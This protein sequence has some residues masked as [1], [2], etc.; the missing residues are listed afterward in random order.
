MRIVSLVLVVLS[1]SVV[2]APEDGGGKPPQRERKTGT[3]TAERP[4]PQERQRAA[5]ENWVRE[6]RLLEVKG[7][8]EEVPVTVAEAHAELERMLSPEALALID[9]K[10]SEHD[11]PHSELTRDIVNGW[12]LAGGSA[13]AQHMEGFGFTDAYEMAV[14]IVDTFWCKRHGEEFRLEERAARYRELREA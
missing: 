1:L 2:A 6:V 9:A 14:T 5:L 11:V 7:K 8:I 10:T 4:T 3:A 12:G 13:L